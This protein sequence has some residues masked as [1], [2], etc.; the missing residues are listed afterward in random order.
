MRPRPRAAPE[1]TMTLSFKLNSGSVI[2]FFF[3]R[4]LVVRCVVVGVTIQ[5]DTTQPRSNPTPM[6]RSKL[7]QLKLRQ[8]RWIPSSYQANKQR[9]YVSHPLGPRLLS[10]LSTSDVTQNV[11]CRHLTFYHC[12]HGRFANAGIIPASGMPHCGPDPVRLALIHCIE[13]VGYAGRVALAVRARTAGKLGSLGSFID[14]GI[15]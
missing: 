9:F 10:Y 8:A 11:L 4:L 13:P 1:T 2:L 5:E 6:F 3:L 7:C 12:S 15:S 14:S